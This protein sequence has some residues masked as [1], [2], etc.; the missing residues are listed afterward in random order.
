MNGDGLAEILGGSCQADDGDL[1]TGAAWLFFS[2]F[3]GSSLMA[4]ADAHLSGFYENEQSGTAVAGGSDVDQDGD[5]DLMLSAR[6]GGSN[7]EGATCLWLGG[8]DDE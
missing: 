6:Y 8:P 7:L 1:Q 3:T 2:P 5:D 4:Q